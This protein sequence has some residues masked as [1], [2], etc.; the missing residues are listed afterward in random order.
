M[1]KIITLPLLLVSALVFTS[2]QDAN[3]DLYSNDQPIRLDLAEQKLTILQLTDLHL[4]FGSDANDRATLRLIRTLV[5]TEQPDL[6]VFTGDL[7]MSPSG[8]RLFHQL[9]A[10]MEGLETPWTFIF[11]NHETDF[12]SYESYLENL[13]QHEHLLFK[14]GPELVDGGYGNFKIETYYNDTP[15]YNLYLLDSHAEAESPLTYDWLSESQVDWY[16]QKASQDATS[17]IKS[18]VFMHI[19]LQEYQLY[20]GEGLDGQKG[21]KV[22]IQGQ[23]TGLFDKLLVH[24]VSQAV[25]VGHDHLNNYSFYQQ[26]ILL[27]YGQASGYNG[28]GNTPKGGRLIVIDGELNLTTKILLDEDYDL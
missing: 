26:G 11:G 10:T 7:T 5:R 27:S 20:E 16:E 23:N 2:C 21:E 1:K 24:G 6:I 19:P 12:N 8:P 22:S 28:Y 17:L 18:S 25:F 9:V 4:T 14:V 13:D 3:L 15:F